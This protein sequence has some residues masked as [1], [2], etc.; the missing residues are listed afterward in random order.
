MGPEVKAL[1]TP[2]D[3]RQGTA[4]AEP[5]WPLLPQHDVH[6]MPEPPR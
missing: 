5:F 2:S 4:A 6:D 3:G 1:G